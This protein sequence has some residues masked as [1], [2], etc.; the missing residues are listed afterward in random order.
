M[1]AFIRKIF[2]ENFYRKFFS[3]FM[4][5]IVWVIV[6]NSITTTRVFQRVPVRILNIPINKTVHGIMPDGFLDRKITVTL[7][8]TKAVLDRMGTNDLEVVIDASNKKN[9]WAVQIVKKN[10][11]S[12]THDVDFVKNVSQI[13]HSE[14]II[15]FCR[16]VTEKVPVRILPPTGTAPSGYQFLD[17]WPKKIYHTISGPEEDVRVL[18][19][20]GVELQFDLSSVTKEELDSIREEASGNN[21]ISFFVPDAWKK[22]RVP[23]LN[24]ASQMIQS[25]ESPNIRL[26]FLYDEKLP[27]D[28]EVPI[29]L[30]FPSMAAQ[31]IPFKIQP[32]DV[33]REYKGS[34][35]FTG[36][37][38]VANVS[39][40]F[41]DTVRKNF[42]IVVFPES[43]A[44]TSFCWEPEFVAEEYLE[45]EYISR[46]M[47][48]ENSTNEGKLS[49]IHAAQQR[50]YHRARYRE[51]MHRLR[52]YRDKIT[53]LVLSI[54]LRGT[55]LVVEEGE[56]N[57]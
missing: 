52:L 45:E 35:F 8:G 10:L 50:D 29:W 46:A 11:V 40:L 3:V 54:T 48:V 26:D 57:R 27:L 7:T 20:E 34:Y 28:T 22:I 42:E 32:N 49:R 13:S 56:T 18:M 1:E 38:F 19:E 55:G 2:V 43:D 51:Y 25:T 39:R 41:L 47:M 24:N 14:L 36:P 33:V 12:V 23:Y 31:E 17:V 53:P 44:A 37:L 16:F 9:D 4:A 5:L 30:F 21:D 6:S 15:R